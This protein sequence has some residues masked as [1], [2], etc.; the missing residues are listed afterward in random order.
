MITRIYESKIPATVERLWKFHSSAEALR[1]LTPESQRVEIVGE[2]LSVRNGALHVIRVRQF[3]IPMV[4]KARLSEVD[5]PHGFR[6]TA[7]Q[8]PFPFWTHLH[9]FID[10][11]DGSILRDT[12]TYRSPGGAIGDWLI[13]RRQIDRL[14]KFRHAST[15]AALAKA[16]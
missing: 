14:F 10:D 12:V 15:I 9:E 4:W 13:T 6:D 2:D 3:G 1:A 8:S 7:E 16:E 11:G 5:P